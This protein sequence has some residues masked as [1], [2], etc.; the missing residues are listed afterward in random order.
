MF[1]LTCCLQYC[2][3]H[4]PPILNIPCNMRSHSVRLTGP[5]PSSISLSPSQSQDSV[6][7]CCLQ[8]CITHGPPVFNMRSH[9]VRLTGPS[10]SSIFLSPSQSQDSVLTCCLQYCI[11]HGPPVFNMRSHSVRLTG[12]SPSSIF[13]SPSQSQDSV[14]TRCLQYCITR[15]PPI[16]NIPY[17]MR[18]HSQTVRLPGPQTRQ[19]VAVSPCW[20]N[21]L[22]PGHVNILAGVVNLVRGDDVTRRRLP[23][24]A[25]DAGA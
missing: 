14:L 17:Y 18:S 23:V 20:H 4:G 2:I 11:T 8:Y 15:G 6:L 25:D 13:L 1:R 7:T 21:H 19:V 22:F 24:D 5:S 10:P 12:P 9:S 3:T 16:L